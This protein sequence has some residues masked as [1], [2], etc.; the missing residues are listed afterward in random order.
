MIITLHEEG[1]RPDPKPRNTNNDIRLA[2]VADLLETAQEVV[3]QATEGSKVLNVDIDAK[4]PKFNDREVV[5]GNIIG[6]GGFCIVRDLEKI[7]ISGS[8]ASRRGSFSSSKSAT[9]DPDMYA[10]GGSRGMFGLCFGRGQSVD[11]R[12]V[13]MKSME[14]DCSYHSKA[15]GYSGVTKFEASKHTREYVAMRSRKSR[16]TGARYVLKSLNKG[17]DKITYM[18]GNVDIAMEAKFLA[19]LDHPNIIELVAVSTSKPC[20]PGY[21]LILEKMTETL[22]GRIKCWMDRER[23]CKSIFGKFSGGHRKELELYH[24]RIAASYDIA[25]GLFYLHN[26]GIVFR[27]LKPDNIGF[28]RH[29]R[30]KLFDFGLAK[31]LKE[32]DRRGDD[33]YRNMTAMTGAIRYMAPEV[34]LGQP[35]NSAC[36]VYSWSMV[37]W[38]ILALEPPFGFFTESMIA[39]RVHKKG[40]RPSIFR[41]WNEVIGEMLRCAWD[42]DLHQR[43][44]FLEITLVLKQELAYSEQA[45]V[46]P[47]STVVGSLGSNGSNTFH[48]NLTFERAEASKLDVDD[49]SEGP[50]SC[51]STLRRPESRSV[52]RNEK[53]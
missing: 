7:R 29:N 22:S 33:T 23:M 6:R 12:S 37:M 43:P 24:E 49:D 15:S 34:G 4:L 32:E 27:D 25:S 41:R 10:T 18:K 30:L 44:N 48:N 26:I 17:V 28:D 51:S 47:G 1:H 40:V 19:A 45:S 35:Y 14:M 50:L 36:D 5:T 38:F 20:T 42:A 21:F 31:E 3:K 8:G 2:T 16:R 52:S 11:D 39:S 46:K 13:S 53:S 9:A